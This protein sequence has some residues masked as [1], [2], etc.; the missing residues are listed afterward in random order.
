LKRIVDA[1]AEGGEG[2]EAAAP[3]AGNVL[4][5]GNGGAGPGGRR[6]ALVCRIGGSGCGVVEKGVENLACVAC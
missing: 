4:K 3:A 2:G 5:D 6:K 1:A